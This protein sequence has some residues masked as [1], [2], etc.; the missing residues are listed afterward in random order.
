MSKGGRIQAH[1]IRS[2]VHGCRRGIFGA[3][4]T[5]YRQRQEDFVRNCGDCPGQ[6]LSAL[7]R[8][9]DVEDNDL[10]DPLDVVAPRQRRR[11]A[12]VA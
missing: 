12:G 1:F 6:R 9:G 7:E 5:A 2:C 11:I 8:G 4:P 10:V 3:D